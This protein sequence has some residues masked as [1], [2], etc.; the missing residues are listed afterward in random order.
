MQVR[1]DGQRRARRSV[2]Q[3]ADETDELRAGDLEEG[4]SQL[5]EQRGRRAAPT[6]AARQWKGHGSPTVPSGVVYSH[7][8]GHSGTEKGRSTRSAIKVSDEAGK[9]SKETRNDECPNESLHEEGGNAEY[10]ASDDV[11]GQ[12]LDPKLMMEARKDEI[13]YFRQMGVYEKMDLNESWKETGKAP[14]PSVGWI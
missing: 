7:S 13:K 14:S 1:H 12:K 11:S 2:G 8:R 5:H 10:T 9:K 3:E 6:R 4:R